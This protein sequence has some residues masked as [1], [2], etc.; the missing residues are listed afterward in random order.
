MMQKRKKRLRQEDTPLLDAMQAYAAESILAFH[1]PGH[2][3][4]RGIHDRYRSLITE[5]GLKMEVSLMEELDDLHDP[6]MCIKDA[7]DLAAEL[8]GADETIFSVNGTTGA[9]Q[10]M[11]LTA[12][13]PGDKILVPRNVHRSIMSGI[14]LAGAV[15]V[16]MQPEINN[17]LGIAMNVDSDAVCKAIANHQ[18]AVAVLVINPTYYG[19]TCD[20]EQIAQ[21]VHEADMVLLVD[22][23]HGPHLKFHPAL[24]LQALDAGADLVAQS[25]HKII[26]SL[27]QTSVLH[28]RFKRIDKQRLHTMNSIV[29]STSPNYLLLA[30][31]DVARLQMATNGY[32]LLD[33]A[34]KLADWARQEINKIEGLYCFGEECLQR[35]GAFSLD[36]TKLTVTVTGLGIDGVMAEQILRQQYKIQLELAD[37]RNVLF[38]ISFADTVVTVRYLIE[39]LQGLAQQFN[40]SISRVLTEKIVLPPIPSR[41]L[42]PREALFAAKSTVAFAKAAGRVCGEFI[43]FYPPGIPLICPGEIIDTSTISYCQQMKALGLKVAGPVDTNL[44]TIRVVE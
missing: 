3:Q 11:L 32:N 38:I 7:Q 33:K 44:N 42:L 40:D 5:A 12:L 24:P 1:T 4:G 27:T 8:Y 2:K 37:A 9:I 26:G 20:I 14:I 39:A 10:I 23:A 21:I 41:A 28:A 22:E 18:D 17:R 34:V 31:L 25:T 43:T 36:K 13:Q 16:F 35:A 6:Q 30:S 29:Q 15:P 19:V